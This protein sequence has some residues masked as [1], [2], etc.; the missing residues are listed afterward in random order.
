MKRI[1]W[2][3]IGRLICWTW[4]VCTIVTQ[5]TAGIQPLA[6]A[7]K[8]SIS[9]LYIL[10]KIIKCI[11]NCIYLIKVHWFGKVAIWVILCMPII[12]TLLVPTLHQPALPR[13]K[14]AVNCAWPMPVVPTSHGTWLLNGVTWKRV[15]LPT[16]YLSRLT[17]TKV[18]PV[19]TS[20]IDCLT[21]KPRH[22]YFMH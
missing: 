13:M 9:F 8:V 12:V 20:T 2:I 17:I 11:L 1:N 4:I 19:V 3:C 14:Y 6:M 10:Q 5:T 16:P 7:V 15:P 22:V 21:F 18:P